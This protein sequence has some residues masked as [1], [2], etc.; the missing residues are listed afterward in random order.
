MDDR[1][2]RDLTIGLDLGDRWTEGWVLDAAGEVIQAFRVRTTEP[3]MT[4]R[5]SSFPPSRVVLEVGTHSPWV[6]RCVVRHGHEAIVANPRRVRLIAENDPK[7]DAM[8]A[9]LLAR[10]GRVDPSLL[11]PIV[12][13]ARV[14][15]PLLLNC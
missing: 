8:D 11:K 3:A 4:E 9:E 1:T 15:R 5:F 12:R 13:R 14:S 7:S 6:S 10:L 2:T